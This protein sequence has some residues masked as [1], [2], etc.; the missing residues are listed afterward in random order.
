MDGSAWADMLSRDA[1]LGYD[2]SRTGF[3][4][5]E[6][7][8][9][10]EGYRLAHLPLVASEHPDVIP[11]RDGTYY[12]MGRHDRLYALVLPV[13]PEALER[14][15]PFRELDDALRGSSFADKIAW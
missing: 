6:G 1:D 2:R 5:G 8:R 13:D 4:S 14:S 11:A 9:L 7:L 12:H 15:G 3:R 10:D